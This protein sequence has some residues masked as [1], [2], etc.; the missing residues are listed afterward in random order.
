MQHVSEPIVITSAELNEPGPNFV[1][2][3][4]AFR[5]MTGYTMEEISGKTP[6][7]LQGLNTARLVLNQLRQNLLQGQ[8]FQGETINYRKDGSEYKVE[9]CCPIGNECGEIMHFISTQRQIR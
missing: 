5:K 9:M 6:H 2:V 8:I 7:I 3:N 4:P 1:F